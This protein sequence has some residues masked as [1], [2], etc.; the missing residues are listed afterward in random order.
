MECARYVIAIPTYWT[1]PQPRSESGPIYDHPT[2]LD[3]EGTLLRTL[4]SLTILGLS[5]VAV[6]VLAVAQPPAQQQAV[7]DR[8][9]AL[10]GDAPTCLDK[11]LYLFS[12]SHLKHLQTHVARATQ[13]ERFS[14]LLCLDG[15]SQIRN[16]GL[17]VAQLLR[18]EALIFVDDDESLDDPDF[19]E[20]AVEFLGSTQDGVLVEAVAGYYRYWDGRYRLKEGAEPWQVYW[21]PARWMNRA[22]EAYLEHPPRLKQTPFAFGGCFALSHTLMARLP[23]DPR[24]PRGEDIDYLINARLCGVPVFLDRNLSLVHA[25]SPKTSTSWEQLCIDAQRFLYE[26]AKLD[27]EAAKYAGYVPVSAESLNPYPGVVLTAD[28]QTRFA[29]AFAALAQAY[30]RQGDTQAADACRRC[31]DELATWHA[32]PAVVFAHLRGLQARW[33]QLTQTLSNLN[34]EQTFLEKVARPYT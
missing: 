20:K 27:P 31:I 12:Y 30:R 34:G 8:I 17:L 24:I 9:R 18:A 14:D 7:E 10:L 3:Q 13:N 6:V 28:V 11:R 33:R 21:N 2:P 22:F 4:E 23:F 29:K 16:V 5:Q 1:A 32:K 19:L 25:P 26:R 15:Y